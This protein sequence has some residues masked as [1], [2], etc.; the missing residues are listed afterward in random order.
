MVKK[1][2]WQFAGILTTLI[3]LIWL[4]IGASNVT[5]FLVFTVFGYFMYFWYLEARPL[6]KAL[7]G[8]PDKTFGD[9]VAYCFRVIGAL[10][11]AFPLLLDACLTYFLI[12][13]LG[14][15]GTLGTAGGCVM[16][17]VASLIILSHMEKTGALEP[18]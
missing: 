4:G 14:L 13:F 10:P 7:K 11:K 12:K 3:A 1:I 6:I 8:I 15:G 9:K 2:L 17:L 16:S 5:Y 18:A